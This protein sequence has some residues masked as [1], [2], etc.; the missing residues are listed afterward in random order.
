MTLGDVRF[1][2]DTGEVLRWLRARARANAVVALDT[3]TT[4][5]DPWH[6]HIRLVQ[7]GDASRAYVFPYPQRHGDVDLCLRFC[8]AELPLVGHNSK[9]DA[10]FLTNA[11]LDASA[12][13]DD[14][15]IMAHLID[16]GDGTR[17]ATSLK[18]LADMY[19]GAGH[20]SAQDD[21]KQFMAAQYETYTTKTGREARKKIRDAYTWETVP[22]DAPLYWYYAGLDTIL[23][24]KLAEFLMERV[25]R[26]YFDL[27][28][29]ELDVWQAMARAE[30]RGMRVDIAYAVEI[31]EQLEAQ[32]AEIASHY[33]EKFLTS[34][35]DLAAHLYEAG[36]RLPQTEKGNDKL[37]EATLLLI[38]H[39]VVKD[40][41]EYRRLTKLK[42]T[43]F[44]AFIGLSVD[45]YIHP[46]INPLGAKTGRMSCERPNLQNVPKREEGSFVRRA[47]I[48]S[49]GSVLVS[50]DFAQIEYRIFASMC[51]EPAMLEA[52]RN[53]EDLHAVTARIAYNDPKIDKSDPRRDVAKNANFSEIY[54]AGIDKFAATA[55][56]TTSEA[57]RFKAQYH[58]QFTR[59]K[60]FTKAVMKHA[61]NNYMAVETTFGRRVPVEPDRIYAAVNYLVQ[62]S[63]AD[64]LKRAIQRIANSRWDQY[65]LL[66]IH[67]ELMFDVPVALADKLAEDLPGLM[68][69]HGTYDVPLEIEI[70]RATRWGEREVA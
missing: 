33:P 53:G 58:G 61:Q 19:L 30:Q 14:T 31:A 63:A 3:E 50:A 44:D 24:A 21:L 22:Q 26:D 51:Q 64:V 23:T 60:P 38:D 47:I 55:G 5:L 62:G 10:Q 46:T 41:L 66:P 28:Q 69:D 9:F 11:G 32:A 36:V 37:D 1:D 20:S 39:P 54:G 49:E 68:E 17:G 6:G 67:D 25:S 15:K 52:I 42:S 29:L 59:V 65:L 40:V 7:F 12:L 57:R 45:G 13:V 35:K 4:G 70:T 18:P 2:P 27:Y 8:A 43:Y 16:S 56:I 48:P 34:K